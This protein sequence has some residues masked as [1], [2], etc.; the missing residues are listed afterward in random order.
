M[1]MYGVIGEERD[2]YR[3]WSCFQIPYREAAHLVT[4]YSKLSPW[5]KITVDSYLCRFHSLSQVCKH[6]RHWSSTMKDSPLKNMTFLFWKDQ[7]VWQKA[8]M[9]SPEQ[10]MRGLIHWPSRSL[11]TSCF[12][13]CIVLCFMIRKGKYVFES[14]NL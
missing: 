12:H 10:W 4:W 5:A 3:L 11:L 13:R 7:G 9:L 1:L 14:L 6:F 8:A 2:N